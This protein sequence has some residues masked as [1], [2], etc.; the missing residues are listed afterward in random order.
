MDAFICAIFT[1]RCVLAELKSLRESYSESLKAASS[2]ITARCDHEKRKS[3]VACITEIIGAGNP[4][5]F[6]V[7]TQDAD[8][9]KKFQEEGLSLYLWHPLPA[10]DFKQHKI[11]QFL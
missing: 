8:L 4:E 3:A 7:A 11:A 1:C 10:N 2:L 9:R 5:H 6:F